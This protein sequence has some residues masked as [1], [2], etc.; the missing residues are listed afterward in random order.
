MYFILLFLTIPFSYVFIDK[1]GH[2]A[3]PRVVFSEY[4]IKDICI[5]CV[6]IL[7]VIAA[8]KVVVLNVQTAGY[9]LCGK[10]HKELNDYY[11]PRLHTQKID[12][13]HNSLK[14]A[15]KMYFIYAVVASI[16]GICYNIYDLH[17]KFQ[18]NW[19]YVIQMLV[20]IPVYI[21]MIFSAFST[22]ILI[23]TTTKMLKRYTQA[24]GEAFDLL[25]Y[26]ITLVYDDQMKYSAIKDNTQKETDALSYTR[27]YT[28]E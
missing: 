25:C 18:D 26:K 12:P 2:W 22:V 9:I 15:N 6:V 11:G 16:L 1:R 19:Y 20:S 27:Y 7:S 14:N 8:M 21:L 3:T 28:I 17:L 4:S 5:L 13:L 23:H 24:Y 10:I